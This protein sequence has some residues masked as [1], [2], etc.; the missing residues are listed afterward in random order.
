VF[1]TC[2]RSIA[3]RMTRPSRLPTGSPMARRC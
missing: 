2:A 1:A 3:R